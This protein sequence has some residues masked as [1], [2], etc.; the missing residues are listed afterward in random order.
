MDMQ[1]K[2]SQKIFSH[3][4]KEDLQTIL[5]LIES[6]QNFTLSRFA[7]GE[8][9]CMN[10]KPCRGI[11]GWVVGPEDVELAKD[12]VE[13]YKHTDSNFFYGISCPCC[14]YR[15]HKWLKDLGKGVW[16]N[17]TFSN[18][19]VNSN[20]EAFTKFL[21]ETLTRPVV[22][23]A[24]EN[25]NL[26]NYP[27][28]VREFVPIKSDVISWYK[29]DKRGIQETFIELS[30]K[31][32]DTLFFISAGPLSEIIISNMYNTNPDNT[33]VDVGSSIDVWTHKRLT[34]DFQNPKTHY[35]QSECVFS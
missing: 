12:L 9:A 29:T 21:E 11:D 6:N 30:K 3:T 1:Q 10:A 4:F 13:S 20:F 17:F 2:E 18:I 8:V 28:K 22:L 24:N 33:Y 14:D 34:R 32:K 23:I 31:Y 15:S 16:S 25:A 27:F 5:N 26:E 19:F 35:A 7:D